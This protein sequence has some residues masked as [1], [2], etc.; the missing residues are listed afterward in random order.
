MEINFEQTVINFK[1]RKSL[2]K[3]GSNQLITTWTYAMWSIQD[4]HYLGRD[5][6]HKMLITGFVQN[7]KVRECAWIWKQKFNAWNVLEFVK[8]YFWKSLHFSC[9]SFWIFSVW[10]SKTDILLN[11]FCMFISDEAVWNSLK[12]RFGQ[13]NVRFYWFLTPFLQYLVFEFLEKSLNSTLN[14][15]MYDATQIPCENSWNAIK[16]QR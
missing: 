1:N 2:S 7:L 4:L 16:L 14:R 9:F 8:K 12:L 15:N 6:S 5:G 10:H 11:W 13:F 3:F